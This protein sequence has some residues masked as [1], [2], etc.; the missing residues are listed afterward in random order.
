MGVGT[1]LVIGEVPIATT[2]ICGVLGYLVRRVVEHMRSTNELMHSMDMR[3]HTIEVNNPNVVHRLNVLETRVATAR[4][5]LA[6]IGAEFESHQ[7]WHERQSA[8]NGVG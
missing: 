1:L 3:L 7:R 8:R 4:E 2:I 6:V 5:D